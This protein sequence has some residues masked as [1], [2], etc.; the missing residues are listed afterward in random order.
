[1][2]ISF[3]LRSPQG[4][5]RILRVCSSRLMLGAHVAPRLG[6][7]WISLIFLPF[8][9]FL[10]SPV[11]SGHVRE[12][13]AT[14]QMGRLRS[15]SYPVCLQM[16]LWWSAGGLASPSTS[17]PLLLRSSQPASHPCLPHAPCKESPSWASG[18]YIQS[19]GLLFTSSLPYIAQSPVVNS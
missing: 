7:A 19:P 11:Q 10:K 2:P 1:M 6:Q 9:P 5:K 18:S 3:G 12:V 16:S 4:P 17:L 13:P 8:S 14:T 15:L